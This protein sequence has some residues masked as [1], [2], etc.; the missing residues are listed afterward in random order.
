MKQTYQRLK[1]LEYLKGVK[2]HPT[3]EQVYSKL[4]LKIPT[5]SLAT[6]HR[7]LNQMAEA[8]QILKLEVKGQYHFD[9]DLSLHQHF[10]CENC[11]KIYDIFHPDISEYALDE[12]DK[13]K[14]QVN[15]VYVIFNG[16]CD[17]CNNIQ[18]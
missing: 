5:I 15:N 3:A 7:N 13:D 4:K 11:G 10:V 16:V 6:V 12:I 18:K 14:F 2:T 17:K 1:I 9:A 8:N